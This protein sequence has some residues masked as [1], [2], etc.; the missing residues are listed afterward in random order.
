M[1]QEFIEQY[2]RLL[3]KQYWEK[4]LARAEIE[5]LSGTWS[6]IFS[7]F[8]SWDDAFDLDSATGDRL[9]KIGSLVDLRRTA[10][11]LPF[12]DEDYRFFLRLKIANN[13]VYG[14]MID[15]ERL[16]IQDVVQFAF[17]GNAYVKDNYDMSLSIFIGFGFP[18]ET[19]QQIVSLG[20]LPKPAAVRYKDVVQAYDAA[21]MIRNSGGQQCMLRL[22][23]GAA[24]RVKYKKYF[25]S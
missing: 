18:E 15:E 21:F 23:N 1:D 13:V 4:P 8:A 17:S 5:L 20:L 9:D 10:Y 7:L 12:S 2:T 6:E 16:S 24:L 11:G 19:I 3:I 22:S 14:T 25:A